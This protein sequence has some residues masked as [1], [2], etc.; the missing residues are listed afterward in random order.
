[1]I[2]RAAIALAA[3]GIGSSPKIADRNRGAAFSR[4]ASRIART[5]I[6][7]TLTFEGVKLRVAGSNEPKV[8]SS[9]TVMPPKSSGAFRFA[10]S[11]ARAR[12][13]VWS[14]MTC[15]AAS[16]PASAADCRRL[17]TSREWLASTAKAP[18]PIRTG[19]ISATAMATTPDSSRA[20]ARR[21]TAATPVS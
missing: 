7:F 3:I 21:L 16:A 18:R 6:A 14:S 19:I 8:T 1:M 15:A 12:A 20:I 4:S 5:W 13:A 17:R 11:T 9:G 10:Y 2:V